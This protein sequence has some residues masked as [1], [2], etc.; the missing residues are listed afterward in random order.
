VPAH[1]ASCL[2]CSWCY[3]RMLQLK[4]RLVLICSSTRA[5][6]RFSPQF[7]LILLEAHDVDSVL[8][9][10]CKKFYRKFCLFRSQSVNQNM[11]LKLR[12]PVKFDFFYVLLFQVIYW[13]LSG[14]ACVAQ[15]CLHDLFLLYAQT[16][17]SCSMLLSS[18]NPS[19]FC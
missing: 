4:L 8:F 1:I 3:F 18:C 2:N 5:N 14:L 17:A 11:R 19:V 13:D 15:N 16:P 9:E 10:Y 6:A 7:I 12:R